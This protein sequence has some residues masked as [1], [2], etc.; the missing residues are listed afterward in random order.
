MTIICAA[1]L[2]ERG[3]APCNPTTSTRRNCGGLEFGKEKAFWPVSVCPKKRQTLVR[4]CPRGRPLLIDSDA[5]REGMVGVFSYDIF[6]VPPLPATLVPLSPTTHSL[7]LV[8][9]L[10]P[11]LFCVFFAYRVFRLHGSH[12]L[13]RG[14]FPVTISPILCFGYVCA[15]R[16]VRACV[17]GSLFLLETGDR[18]ENGRG[19]RRIREDDHFS[20]W[21]GQKKRGYTGLVIFQTTRGEAFFFLRSLSR[22]KML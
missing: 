1:R 21:S 22:N 20:F 4:Y 3:M 13:A 14:T 18:T 16:G 11:M 8:L 15:I 6:S 7:F 5:P 2:G 19:D 12:H 10:L 17:S 9:L